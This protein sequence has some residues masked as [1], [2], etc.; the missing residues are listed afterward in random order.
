MALSWGWSLC[1]ALPPLFGF[2][3]YGIESNGMGCAPTWKDPKDFN[4]NIFLFVVGFF[5]PLSIII[6]TSI[7]VLVIVHSVSYV[8]IQEQNQF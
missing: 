4:Y 8:L 7:N 2:G 6:F 1:L 5:F 3:S